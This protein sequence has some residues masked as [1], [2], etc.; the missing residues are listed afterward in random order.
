[1]SQI[2]YAVDTAFARL[3]AERVGKIILNFS[4]LEFET[5]HW[6]LQ[7]SEQP[8]RIPEF[9]AQRFGKRVTKINEYINARGF[10]Q[11]W[12]TDALAAWSEAVELAR[13]RNRLAHNPI[14]FAWADEVGKGE[15]DFIGVT[16][17]QS[18]DL[19]KG[20][21]LLSKIAIEAAID[22]VVVLA[23]RIELLRE[24]WCGLRDQDTHGL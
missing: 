18:L 23:K 8:D 15:P 1:M 2:K 4:C 13:L 12:K 14:V 24:E 22:R 6:L 3:W 21:P 20:E 16:E 10:T 11:P 17:M 19:G 9:A 5:Y 7:M